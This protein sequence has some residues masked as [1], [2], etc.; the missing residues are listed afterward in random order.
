MYP[1]EHSRYFRPEVADFP[2]QHTREYAPFEVAEL[3]AG[4]GFAV[5]WMRTFDLFPGERLGLIDYL[6]LVPAF[7][8]YNALRGRHPKH[9]RPGLRKP[10]LFV[11]ARKSGPPAVRYP[12]FLYV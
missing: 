11:L 8:I 9:M 6:L 2:I 10:H 5:E 12:G 7:V 4:A 3:L 1:L